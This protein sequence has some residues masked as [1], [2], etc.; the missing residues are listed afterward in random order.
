MVSNAVMVALLL[1]TTGAMA[2]GGGPSVANPA[3][4]LQV[5][6]SFT[7]AALALARWA[8]WI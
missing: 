7:L 4:P 3:N 8:G 5:G 1:I 2:A 6:L